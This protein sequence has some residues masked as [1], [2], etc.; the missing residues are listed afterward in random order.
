MEYVHMSQLKS[1]EDY[2][3]KA[4]RRRRV[5]VTRMTAIKNR[6]CENLTATISR[7]RQMGHNI[8]AL[9]GKIGDNVFTYYKLRPTTKRN[10]LGLA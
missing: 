5:R 3:L 1:C 6:W 7:L 8:V 4:L 9:K 2:I 10:V